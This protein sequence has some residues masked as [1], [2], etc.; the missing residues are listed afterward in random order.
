MDANLQLTAL[1]GAAERLPED[2]KSIVMCV[3]DLARYRQTPIAG[4]LA[5]AV[6]VELTD[7]VANLPETP[8][9]RALI[10]RRPR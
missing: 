9:E 2:L 10:V 6:A 1:Y 8:P 4:D 5:V 3:A 7:L